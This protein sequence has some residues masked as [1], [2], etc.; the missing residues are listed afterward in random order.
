MKQIFLFFA[1][2]AG[3][4]ASAAVTIT[5]LGTDYTANEIK[6]K[7]DWNAVPYDNKVWI[8]VDFCPI[9]GSATP[10]AS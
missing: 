9:T 2:L 10:A 1:M 3:I 4:T 7:V 5:P 6:F 8:W